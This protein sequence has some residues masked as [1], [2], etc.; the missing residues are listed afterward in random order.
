MITTP[1]PRLAVFVKN[2]LLH[3]WNSIPIIFFF[4]SHLIGTLRAANTE[5]TDVKVTAVSFI[6]LQKNTFCL[7]FPLQ[8]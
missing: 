4:S 7:S 2:D 3:C 6:W 5:N 8:S 1:Q